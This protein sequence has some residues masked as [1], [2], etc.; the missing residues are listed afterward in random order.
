[1]VGWFNQGIQLPTLVEN[2]NPALQYLRGL[3]PFHE[4]N[5]EDT[6]K[7]FIGEQEALAEFL[8]QS[9]FTPMA[10]EFRHEAIPQSMML[11]IFLYRLAENKARKVWGRELPVISEALIDAQADRLVE[12]G[13]KAASLAWNY[14]TTLDKEQPHLAKFL[15][16][17]KASW[18]GRWGE[19][20]EME[21]ELITCP[22]IVTFALVNEA[23][24][25]RQLEELFEDGPEPGGFL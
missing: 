25:V 16:A 6:M 13:S 1:M 19:E 22:P 9:M 20:S 4:E 12:Q 18:L 23:I 11:T 14:F 17:V 7:E 24:G 8:G 2:Q 15:E 3:H 5:V 21:A 10:A